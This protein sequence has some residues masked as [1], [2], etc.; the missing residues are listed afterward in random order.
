MYSEK[1]IEKY[2]NIAKQQALF[3]SYKKEHIGAVIVYKNKIIAKGCNTNYSHTLQK[4]YNIYRT[5]ETREYDVDKMANLLHAEMSCIA[6]LLNHV[7]LDNT[8]MK[9]YSIFVYRVDKNGN[10]QLA[11]PCLSCM[12]ALDDIG[13]KNIYY[14]TQ[15]GFNYERR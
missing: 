3:S 8:N 14:T 11:R 10:K 7:A 9:Y 6:T 15:E 4:T 13:I 5:N 2:F 1:R 12:H